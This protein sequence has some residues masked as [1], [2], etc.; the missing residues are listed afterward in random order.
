M[1]LCTSFYMALARAECRLS[2]VERCL[3]TTWAGEKFPKG[4]VDGAGNNLTAS[5]LCLELFQQ[6]WQKLKLNIYLDFSVK[7]SLG[8]SSPERAIFWNFGSLANNWPFIC[9]R[10]QNPPLYWRLVSQWPTR[11]VLLFITFMNGSPS[12][13]CSHFNFP[14]LVIISCELF[15]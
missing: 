12:F 8:S 1:S 3:G 7:L 10:R 9:S 11:E 5:L 6:G 2:Q 4:V 15:L 13:L 14:L